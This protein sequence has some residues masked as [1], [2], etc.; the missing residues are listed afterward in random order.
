MT[1]T[2]GDWFVPSEVD[3]IVASMK[4]GDLIQ[5]EPEKGVYLIRQGRAVPLV[6]LVLP[7]IERKRKKSKRGR[8]G[9]R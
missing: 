5:V 9:R 1:K 8:R 3:E 6:E 7:V 4:P 2:L